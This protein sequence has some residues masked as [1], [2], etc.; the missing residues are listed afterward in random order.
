MM[1][2]LLRRKERSKTYQS[3]SLPNQGGGELL[4]CLDVDC[5]PG[6][7]IYREVILEDSGLGDVPWDH[8]LVHDNVATI[9][10]R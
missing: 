9:M 6:L 1:N 5:D 10:Q 7:E 2:C 8:R 3:S 4:L